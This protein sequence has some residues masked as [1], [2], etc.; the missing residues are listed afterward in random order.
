[1]L[2]S[3]STDETILVL[4]GETGEGEADIVDDDEVDDDDDSGEVDE[5]G[6]GVDTKLFDVDAEE[7][8]TS[9]FKLVSV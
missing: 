3:V 7:S 8:T 9:T 2:M 5:L 4:Q 6:E 1:M